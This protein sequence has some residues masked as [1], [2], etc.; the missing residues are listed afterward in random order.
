MRPPQQI[1]NKM[2]C[3]SSPGVHSIGNVPADASPPGKLLVSPST[4]VVVSS[5]RGIGGMG[6]VDS[7]IG[8]GGRIETDPGVVTMGVV[9]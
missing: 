2:K 1:P 6:G 3:T 9:D 4:S 5:V 8:N 7:T